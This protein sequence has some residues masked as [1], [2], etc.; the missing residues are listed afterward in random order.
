MKHLLRLQDL[1][2]E[3]IF[4][5]LNL[6]DQLKYEQAHGIPHPRLAGKTLGMIFERASTR[7]R[8]SFEVGRYQ[9]GGM[10]LFLSAGDLQFG[11]GEPM[12]DTARVLSR[13][14]DGIMIRAHSQADIEELARYAT[15]PVINGL[16]DTAH[17]CQA[18]ADLMTIRERKGALAG[19]RLGFVG[20]GNNVARSLI[21]GCLQVGM[22][23]TLA[24]PSGYE[25][26]DELL[27]QAKA[28]GDFTL[29][30]D[31]LEAARNAD[32]LYTD[33]WTSMGMEA[34]AA[35]RARD[36]A[37]YQLDDRLLAAARPDRMV[38]HCLPAHRG[39]EI[40]DAVFEAHAE[41]IFDQAENRLH[42]QKAVLV[43]LMKP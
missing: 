22:A 38:L 42:V 14:V 28:L 1:R 26:A 21:T 37:G 23:V 29:T 16:S 8:I 32:V 11:R 25:P 33:V 15:V 43:R 2:K 34:E 24:C 17:P 30:H 20:D 7:T 40:T 5:I 41:E 6:A 39:E 13:L 19:L 18:L 10:A 9:L 36:F 31:P 35:V 4:S 3:D 27:A 12:K